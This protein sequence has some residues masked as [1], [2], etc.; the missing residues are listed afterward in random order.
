MSTELI[1]I[2]S[3]GVT[4]IG[5]GIALARLILRSLREL[6]E[7]MQAE[8]KSLRSE[9]QAG[10]KGQGEAI[11]R[12]RADVNQLRKDVNNVLGRVAYIEGLLEAMRQP[13]MEAVAEGPGRYKET[14]D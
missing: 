11:D 12:L 9:M 4:G 8:I 10:F 6:R 7:D 5:V 1:A 3:I 14:S 13:Q 2:C